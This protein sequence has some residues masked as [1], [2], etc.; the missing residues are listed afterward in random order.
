MAMKTLLAT[1]VFVLIHCCRAILLI[2]GHPEPVLAGGPFRVECLLQN[3]EYSIS[4]VRM[5]TYRNNEWEDV[6][7]DFCV[8]P[9]YAAQTEDK[10]VLGFHFVSGERIGPY[11]CVLDG[12]N[13]TTPE[14]TPPLNFTV[15]Y[16]YGP[17]LSV[18]GYPRDLLHS[19]LTVKPGDDVVVNCAS[20]SSEEADLYWYKE[21]DDWTLPSPALALTHVNASDEGNYTCFSN[22][23]TIPSLSKN[24]TINLTVPSDRQE[25]MWYQWYQYQYQNS[26]LITIASAV[27]AGV[28]FLGVILS[29]TAFFCAKKIRTS[30]G[31]S[32]S[33]PHEQTEMGA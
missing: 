21:D 1:S 27:S 26:P 12:L 33:A 8:F 11:R 22:H 10:L 5:E 3:S 23:P 4:N 14:F 6:R 2:R 13:V 16:L 17:W 29:V 24:R 30:N 25:R 19:T 31:A 32:P 18:E 9:V 7:T 15:H 20:K 28:V